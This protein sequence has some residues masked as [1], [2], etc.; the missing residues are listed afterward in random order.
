[1]ELIRKHR[2]HVMLAGIFIFAWATM[3]YVST[4]L[5]MKETQEVVVPKIIGSPVHEAQRMMDQRKLKIKIDKYE[6]A[7]GFPPNTVIS[8]SV[9]PGTIVKENRTL[10]LRVSKQKDRQDVPNLI[11]KDILESKE[12]VDKKGLRLSNIAY[13]CS[14]TIKSGKVISQNP[15]PDELGQDNNIQVLVSSGTCQNQF[16]INSLV[17]QKIEANVK[18]EF[19]DKDV[20][21]KLVS[22]QTRESLKR[23]S[24]VSQD[25]I[26]G[27]V[28]KSGDS[29]ILN[30]EK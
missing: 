3:F 20:E 22:S 14:K 10:L 11:G 27:S 1:M 4:R 23:A 24:V 7:L 6:D 30:M 21:I 17:D 9:E 8:Q 18:K 26:A 12:I 28:V 15:L 29:V 5:L 16:V 2:Q 19:A 13:G 25:P